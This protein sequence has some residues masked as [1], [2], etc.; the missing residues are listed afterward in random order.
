[1]LASLEIDIILDINKSRYNEISQDKETLKYFY[2]VQVLIFCT[3]LGP[4][5]M[6]LHQKETKKINLFN[7]I[8]TGTKIR[9]KKLKIEDQ[10]GKTKR[11]SKT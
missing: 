11:K 4:I 2:R 9:K 3:M 7:R 8:E 5:E 1:M 10:R 6:S